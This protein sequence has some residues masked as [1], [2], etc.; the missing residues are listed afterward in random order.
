MKAARWERIR[1]RRI[2]VARRLAIP[3]EARCQE[4]IDSPFERDWRP[5]QTLLPKS[6]EPL[7]LKFP[8]EAPDSEQMSFKQSADGYPRRQ[9]AADTGCAED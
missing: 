7:P 6:K 1:R 4:S 3:S 5:L 8:N 2:E 9:T